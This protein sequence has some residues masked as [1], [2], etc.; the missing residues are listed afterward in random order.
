M[1][2]FQMVEDKNPY[3]ICT[4]NK[5]SDCKNCSINEKLHCKW[6][7]RILTRFATLYLPFGISGFIGMIVTGMLTSIWWFL[8]G[9]VIFITLFFTL[10]EI[11]ILCR[12]CPFYAEKGR[13]I[14][15]LANEGLPKVW[16]YSPEPVSG[17]EKVLLLICFGF[18]GGFPIG[19]EIYGIWYLYV[20]SDHLGLVNFTSLYETNFILMIGITGATIFTIICF[21]SVITLFFC[22]YCINFS[23][24]LNKVA[25][26]IV[27]EYLRKNPVMREAWEK[28]GYT[29]DK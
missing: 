5:D 8:I 25:K 7:S 28:N 19:T 11:R 17:S 21:F 4:W 18:F 14:H 10:I 6:D 9:Y 29:L 15:C 20:N 16:K 13:T 2:E 24:P 12:H 27:D 22:P 26:E 23:C 1:G 3:K